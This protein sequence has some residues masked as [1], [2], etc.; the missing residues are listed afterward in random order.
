MPGTLKVL[1]LTLCYLVW[2]LFCTDTDS[3]TMSGLPAV[4]TLTTYYHAWNT[5]GID[6]D[7]LLPCLA[8]LLY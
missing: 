3:A 5:Q 1:I 4:L 6:T 8:Q 2:P 7:S